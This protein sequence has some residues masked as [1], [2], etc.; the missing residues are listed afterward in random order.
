VATRPDVIETLHRSF[1]DVG[2][3]VIETDSFGS[4]SLVLAE[5]DLAER[6]HE[7]NVT[8]ATLARRLADEYSTPDRPKFVA[9]SMG[10]APSSPPS[11]RR[12]SPPCATPT[13]SRQPAC[14]KA[15]STC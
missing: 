8:A 4:F 13:K 5:Y 15:A 1:L 9:G 12:R 6:A 3:D 2:V 7:L 11:A 14:S 10:R